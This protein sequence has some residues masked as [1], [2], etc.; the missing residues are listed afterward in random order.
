MALVVYLVSNLRGYFVGLMG[1]LLL[2]LS[3]RLTIFGVATKGG[4]SRVNRLT[5]IRFVNRYC[6]RSVNV[7]DT[8]GKEGFKYDP[9]SNLGFFPYD[10]NDIILLSIPRIFKKFRRITRVI[11]NLPNSVTVMSFVKE[12]FERNGVNL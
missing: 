8:M 6:T 7:E 9:T 5:T 4:A 3:F 11:G 12:G 2:S 10:G 1:E